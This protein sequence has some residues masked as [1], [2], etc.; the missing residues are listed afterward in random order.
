MAKTIFTCESVEKQVPVCSIPG[1][2]KDVNCKGVCRSHY[3]RDYRA[4]RSVKTPRSNV[5]REAVCVF[6]KA[7]FSYKFKA[8]AGRV[9]CSKK[10]SGRAMSQRMT[11]LRSPPATCKAPDCGDHAVRSGS[12]LCEKHYAR[13]RRTGSYEK[14]VSVRKTKGKYFYISAKDHPLANFGGYCYAHRIVAYDKYKGVCQ[15]CRWCGELLDWQ[16]AVVD[17]LNEVKTDN[18]P[19]NLVVACNACNRSR[20]AI[21]PFIR[22]CSDTSFEAF[23]EQARSYRRS[24][25]DIT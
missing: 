20:G 5:A 23:V 8:G 24:H 17:H 2:G 22:K 3:Q 25:G 18:R 14:Q 19:E 9:F 16:S 15:P 12:E 1:C 6:C 13:F 4:E 21:L 7:N 10:C 11:S